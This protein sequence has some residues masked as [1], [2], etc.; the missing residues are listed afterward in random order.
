LE[1]F[2]VVACLVRKGGKKLTT[3]SD[4]E[5]GG[6]LFGGTVGDG[7]QDVFIRNPTPKGVV[8]FVNERRVIDVY[9]RVIDL[10]CSFKLI[11]ERRV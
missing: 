10:T 3:W 1:S 9:Y 5:R 11:R 6:A 7:D 2:F 8:G 4:I